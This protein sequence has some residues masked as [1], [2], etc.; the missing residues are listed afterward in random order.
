MAN[1]KTGF[2]I[3]PKYP[4]QKRGNGRDEIKKGGRIQ[5]R[6]DQRGREK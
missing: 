5:L 2:K 6:F 3:H 4:G 1:G